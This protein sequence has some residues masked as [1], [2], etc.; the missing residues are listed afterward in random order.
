MNNWNYIDLKRNKHT[1]RKSL[2]KVFPLP[3]GA[4]TVISRVKP[5][6]SPIYN[7]EEEETNN[8]EFEELLS[9]EFQRIQLFLHFLN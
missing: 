6:R 9:S 2:T 1:I 8:R 7:E 5:H 4:Q 3:V